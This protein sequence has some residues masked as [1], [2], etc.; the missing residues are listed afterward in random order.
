MSVSSTIKQ[1]KILN[2]KRQI[3]L[4]QFKMLFLF[5]FCCSS[6][7]IILIYVV[8]CNYGDGAVLQKSLG[9]L[10][11]HYRIICDC[12]HRIQAFEQSIMR[13]GC[14]KLRRAYTNEVCLIAV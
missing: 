5:S 13:Y 8:Y 4:F 2:D 1:M 11:H 14:L 10:V 9:G 12:V 6:I 7:Y 3:S